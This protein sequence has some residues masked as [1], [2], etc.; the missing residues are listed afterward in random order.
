MTE[1]AN[2]GVDMYYSSFRNMKIGSFFNEVRNWLKP[3]ALNNFEN[4]DTMN[5]FG[6]MAGN[7]MICDSDKY[8]LVS[9]FSSF[10]AEIKQQIEAMSSD[11]KFSVDQ[12]NTIQS[13]WLRDAYVKLVSR[14]KLVVQPNDCL[15]YAT[16]YLQ[17]VYRF[18]TI[19][20]GN[21]KEA[22]PFA[23]NDDLIM[24]DSDLICPRITENDMGQVA[25]E[26]YNQDLYTQAVSLY[27]MLQCKRPLFCKEEVILATCCAMLHDYDNAVLHFSIAEKNYELSPELKCL[28]ASCLIKNNNSKRAIEIYKQLYKENYT[29]LP[30]YNFAVALS[31]EKQIAEAVEVLFKEDFLRPNQMRVERLMLSCLLAEKKVEQALPYC[32]KM[33]EDKNV[34][35]SDFINIGHV[36][37]ALKNNAQALKCYRRSKVSSDSVFVFSNEERNTLKDLGFSEMSI[38]LMEDAV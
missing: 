6:V 26:A 8:S 38:N 21:E 5:R 12:I 2:R 9:M 16:M 17:D 27:G 37:F 23:D 15:M 19:K 33:C 32:E 36:Y 29:E 4:D 14:L 3:F 35:Q 13:A 22:N 24:I 31:N 7:N 18:F 28:F 11:F 10:P 25:A 34:K 30:L 20:L 1:K